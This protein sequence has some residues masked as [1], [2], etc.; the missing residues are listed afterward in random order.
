MNCKRVL[1]YVAA[2]MQVKTTMPLLPPTFF[3]C[4]LPRT[5][6]TLLFNLLACDP[7]CRAPLATDIF[8]PVSPIARSD[9]TGQ[10]QRILEIGKSSE[11]F[12]AVRLNDYEQKLLAGHPRYA[13]EEDL[14]L[15]Y[16]A[17]VN[18]L[19]TLLTSRDNTELSEWF[20]NDTNKDFAYEYHK[21]FFQMLNDIDTPRSHW[22]LK[23]PIHTFFLDTLLRHYP[24]ASLIMTHR[25][26][27]EVLPSYA[28]F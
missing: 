19:N 15:L 1:N 23:S 25:R 6:S 5:G 22:L 18:F 16:Q 4:G 26:L 28:R 9:T 10:A 7:K 14:F 12:R 3:V 11:L 27:D 24:S 2:N 13:H 17:G 8:C 21:T 20:C